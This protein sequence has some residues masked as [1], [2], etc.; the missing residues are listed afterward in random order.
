MTTED[1]LIISYSVYMTLMFGWL[2]F[3]WSGTAYLVFWL[4]HSGWWFVLTCVISCPISPAK[5]RGLL[6]GQEPSCDCE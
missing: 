3:V 5:W 6:T 2:V 4:G 1:K